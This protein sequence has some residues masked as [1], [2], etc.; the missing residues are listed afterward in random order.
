MRKSAARKFHDAA[1]GGIN[2]IPVPTALKVA[3]MAGYGPRRRCRSP[4]VAAAFWG[5]AVADGR[6]L[7]AGLSWRGRPIPG[8]SFAGPTICD[9]VLYHILIRG[10]RMTIEDNEIKIENLE[11]KLQLAYDSLDRLLKAIQES[12]RRESFGV[13]NPDRKRGFVEAAQQVANRIRELEIEL[14]QAINVA[15]R[16]T[17]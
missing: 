14:E 11:A 1:A 7:W 3:A 10:E 4:T 13:I 16:P 2:A 9:N 17:G 6:R 5:S 12:K 8:G 15:G